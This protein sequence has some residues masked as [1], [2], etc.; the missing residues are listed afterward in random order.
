MTEAH[1]PNEIDG[2]HEGPIKT[3]KQLILAVLFAFVVPVI[4]IIL[5]VLF[6]TADDRP[7]AGSDAFGEQAV[8]ERI[9]PVGMVEVKDAT[10]IA[11]MK[12]GEQVFAAQCTAC[13]TAGALGAP[14]FGD[15]DAWAPRIKAGFDALLHSALA[16]KGQMPPQGGG[17]FSDYEIARA[18]V[19]MADKGGAKFPEPPAPSAAA[20]G[21]VTTLVAATGAASVVDL[22]MPKADP[23]AGTPIAT[24]TAALNSQVSTAVPAALPSVPATQVAAAAA[25]ADPPALFKQ[26]C[27]VCHIAGVAGAPKVG[28]KAAWAP[29]IALG[30]DAL[31]AVA[32]KGL[33]AMPPRG[34]STASDAEIKAVV[35]YMVNASK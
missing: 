25:P 10:D 15:A 23:N 21:A 8:S 28:D 35:T 27:S 12:T 18:V 20:S 13:H 31:T 29:R 19:Y 11:S 9:R 32:I 4:G 34:G 33:G 6:V 5:L 7:A 24:P 1:E 14:K 3:P 30:I 26:V 2:P 16:G 22:G 17:D